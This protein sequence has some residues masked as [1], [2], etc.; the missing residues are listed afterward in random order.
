LYLGKKMLIDKDDEVSDDELILGKEV[1]T[2]LTPMDGMTIADSEVITQFV[3]P[4]AGNK[5]GPFI[6]QEKL[7]QGVSCFVFRGWDE[8]ERSPV[9]VKIVN[10]GNVYDR[11]AALKQMRTESA[12]IARVKHPRVVRFI[13]FGMDPRYPYLVTEFIEGRSLGEILRTG[14]SLPPAWAVYFVSQMAD[15]LG[16]VWQASLVHRDIKPDN[17]LIS[18]NGI[19]KLIDFGLAK[20]SSV[21]SANKSELAGTAAYLAPEQ[22]RDSGNVDHR[23]DIY[24]LGVSFFEALTGRLPFE[25]KNKLQMIYSHLNT[26]PPRPM[27]INPEVPPIIND[28]CLWML[29]KNPDDRPQ[30]HSEI[31]QAFDSIMG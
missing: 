14:G 30:N 26:A 11:D 29:A 9:A 7:G 18:P 13:D 6:L 5:I 12:A 1:D 20:A 2:D 17:V 25:G 24:S 8:R 19:A 31:R 27:D 16:A 28:L 22:A 3:T 23:A 4:E 21:K 15:G 10:W